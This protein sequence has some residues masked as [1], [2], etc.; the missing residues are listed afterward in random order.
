MFSLL[1][2]RLLNVILTTVFPLDEH[3]FDFLTLI[4]LNVLTKDNI[5]TFYASF[6]M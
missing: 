6:C 3:D 5:L 4:G 1:L 2:L